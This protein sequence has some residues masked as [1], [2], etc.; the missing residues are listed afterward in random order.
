MPRRAS[1]VSVGLVSYSAVLVDL[2]QLRGH[3]EQPGHVG[4]LGRAFVC[5][6]HGLCL[7]DQLEFE[8]VAAAMPAY[9]GN[10]A[11][12]Q[13]YALVQSLRN[14]AGHPWR[15]DV[16]QTQTTETIP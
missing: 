4:S 16:E 2:E 14:T 7:A 13:Y 5:R 3:H 11:Q 12:S 10:N 9:P 6:P 15:N 8:Q 1:L